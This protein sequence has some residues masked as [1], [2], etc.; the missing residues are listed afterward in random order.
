MCRGC[1]VCFNFVTSSVA[2]RFSTATLSCAHVIIESVLMICR[3]LC[4]GCLGVFRDCFRGLY[5]CPCSTLADF[6]AAHTLRYRFLPILQL[7][8]HLLGL[9]RRWGDPFAC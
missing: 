3:A 2:S 9:V 6:W 1:L 5:K 8:L 4:R 7:L